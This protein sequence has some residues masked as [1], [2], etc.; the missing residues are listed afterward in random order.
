MKKTILFFTIIIF[1]TFLSYNSFSKNSSQNFNAIKNHNYLLLMDKDSREIL[2]SKNSDTRMAPSS[3]TKLMTAYVVFDQIKQGNV[4]L[5]NYCV[6]GK[7]AWRKRGSTMFL[8]YGDVVSISDLVKGLLTVSG[9]DASIALAQA[10][11]KDY[12]NFISLMNLKAKELGMNNSK[13]QNPHGLNEDGHYMSL[14][15][16]ATLIS[17]I[18]DDFPEFAP[19]L[20]MRKFTYGDITQYNSN[21]LVKHRYKGVVAGKTGHTN[22]GGYGITASVTRGNRTLIGIVNKARTYRKRNKMITQLFDFGFDKFHK[23]E[24]F[25]KDQEI[26]RLKTWIGEKDSVVV[27]TNQDIAFNIP[28]NVN[29]DDV[30]VTVDYNGPVQT[31][32]QEG[33]KIATLKVQIKDYKTLNYSLFAAENVQKAKFFTSLSHKIAYKTKLFLAKI[34]R[35]AR[36][37]AFFQQKSNQNS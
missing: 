27:R 19:F 11:G 31:P 10:V 34:K 3:M 14:N 32:I 16:L 23:I 30:K 20:R 36:N 24:L 28:K 7:D 4:S 18:H 2:L 13:F 25:K 26:T 37:F 22:D 6:I 8:N 17:R 12:D 21:P 9:N 5:N 35:K 15:D 29:I 33:K 1:Q